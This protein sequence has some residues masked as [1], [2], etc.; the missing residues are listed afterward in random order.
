MST[1]QQF[2]ICIQNEG[3]PASLE[4]WK[5]YRSLPDEKAAKHQLI[6]IIDESGEDYLYS[7]SW[8]VPIKLPQAVEKAMLTA[9]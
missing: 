7:E 8:F 9:S 6:R 4:L 1:K 5:V 3:Y 2:A